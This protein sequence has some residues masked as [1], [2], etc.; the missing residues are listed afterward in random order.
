MGNRVRNTRRS[1]DRSKTSGGFARMRFNDV[2]GK[3]GYTAGDVQKMMDYLGVFE[4]NTS[5]LSN[6]ADRNNLA[7]R[8]SSLGI[9]KEGGAPSSLIPITNLG[10]LV[11]DTAYGYE[12]TTEQ[13]LEAA[14]L[15]DKKYGVI[16][17]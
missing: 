7:V 3:P 17:K 4:C 16:R 10:P 13:L 2:F 9:K 5:T 14:G 15:I 6:S 11:A 8:L 1:W 12:V